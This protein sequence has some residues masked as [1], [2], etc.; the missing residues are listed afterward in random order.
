MQISTSIVYFFIDSAWVFIGGLP[1][2]LSEGDVICVF[3]QYGEIV[4]LNL[5]RDKK[6][7]KQ[8]G[9][10]F[11]CYEDQR[12][13][14]LAVDNLNGIKILGKTI[15]VDH[16]SDYKPPKDD[17]RYDDETRRIHAEGCAPKKQLPVE[18]IKRERESSRR[19]IKDEDRK[20][21]SESD[22][23]VKRE[24]DKNNK[25]ESSRKIKRESE[26]EDK[27]VKSVSYLEF[28]NLVFFPL[29][30]YYLQTNLPEL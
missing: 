26:K 25:T 2:D 23:R 29:P 8:K 22:A 16:V 14:V 21:K 11:L 13:T 3:S 24:S 1:Y 28:I 17:D 10:G 18:Y 7:V 6:T 9:F 30:K 15:R 20:I 12:S 27:K 19:D 4:N 5:I